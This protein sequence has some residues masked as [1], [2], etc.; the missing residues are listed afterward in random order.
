MPETDGSK[1]LG[2]G[3]KAVD[4]PDAVS[5][6]KALSKKAAV[7]V[8]DVRTIS[9]GTPAADSSSR[10]FTDQAAKP[11]AVKDMVVELRGSGWG[12][13]TGAAQNGRESAALERLTSADLKSAAQAE[14]FLSRELH[15]NLNGDIVREA[16]VMLRDGGKGLIRLKLY[17]EALGNVQVRLS[18]SGNSVQGVIT[19]ESPEALSAFEHERAALETAFRE[20]GFEGASLDMQM[21]GGGN[22]ERFDGRAAGAFSRSI[23]ASEY[24]AR[25]AAP[26]VESIREYEGLSIF[27]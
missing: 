9:G 22:E 18:L 26:R 20:S 21:S 13:G 8:A 3:G 23:A 2:G 16:S 17:P 10:L 14:S 19:V 24:E 1:K 5:K 27:A 12:D 15:N 11:L 7:S 4:A 6:K 25:S